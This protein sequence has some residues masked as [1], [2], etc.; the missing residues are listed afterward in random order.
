[1]VKG[2]KLGSIQKGDLPNFISCGRLTHLIAF[3]KYNSLEN[4]LVLL[5]ISTDQY[6]K[7]VVK[8]LNNDETGLIIA[9]QKAR[10]QLEKGC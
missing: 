9:T 2:L 1:M 4:Q 6:D 10:T 5:A 7:F 8:E 3:Y